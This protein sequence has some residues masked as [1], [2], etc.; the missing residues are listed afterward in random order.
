MGR[1]FISYR[2]Q[3]SEWAAR[4]V[5]DEL[6]EHF[7]KESVF[8]DIDTL[9]PGDDFV[10]AIERA[11][12]NCHALVALIGPQWLT[13]RSPSGARRLDESNDFVRL[14]IEAARRMTRDLLITYLGRAPAKRVLRGNFIRGRKSINVAVEFTYRNAWSLEFR[15]VNFFAAGVYNLLSDRD[16]FAT[17]VKY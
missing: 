11:V 17:T 7:G 2:R 6:S 5:C 9:A 10:E 4:V 16:Y 8:M 13:I 14:E 1:L 12:G 3:D 15:Y